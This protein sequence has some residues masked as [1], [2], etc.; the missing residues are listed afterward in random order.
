MNKYIKQISDRIFKNVLIAEFNDKTVL[1][2]GANGLIGGFIADFLHYLNVE[3]D[4]NIKIILT[5]LSKKPKRLEHLLDNDNV[6]YLP[7]DLADEK[8]EIRFFEKGLPLYRNIKIDYCFYCAG[9]AQPGKFLSDPYKTFLLNV[10][11][12]CRTFDNVFSNNKKAKAIYISSSEIYILNDDS[13]SHRETDFLNVSL[14]HK[15]I[16][17][18]LGKISGE[19]N[20]NIIRDLGYDVKSA[21]VS[22]CYGPG[23]VMSD[24]RVM[25]DLTR[26]G[27]END[28]IDLFD[29][30][31]SFRK[32]QHISDCCVMLFNILLRGKNDV[33]N[34]G[35]KEEITIYD[36]AAIIADKFDK[37]VVKGIVNNEVANS[38]PKRVS[39]SR[40][41][42]EEEFGDFEFTTFK[43]GMENYLNW[44]IDAH[45]E[46]NDN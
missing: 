46:Y 27:I 34:L 5:S 37:K 17:Y 26:K 7:I 3:H 25:S 40:I 18:I 30:G 24:S 2:T 32:Y 29:D 33:Y 16:P 36:M 11:G 9:Y 8:T 41:R 20:V 14:T 21:R 6:L 39:I 1:I 38:A 22:L 15:R 35:G 13:K 45:R 42:Y 31:S 4:Y 12:L 23:H 19:Y 10:S 43:D 44:Y 28:T